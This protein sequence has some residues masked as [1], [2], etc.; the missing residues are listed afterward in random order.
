MKSKDLQNI[1]LYKYR[2]SDAPTKICRGLN[3]GISLVTVKRGCQ[4]IRRTGS[5]ELSGTHGGLRV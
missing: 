3:G 1:V 4:M 5:I 2:N